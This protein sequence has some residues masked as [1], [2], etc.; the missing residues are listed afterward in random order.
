MLKTIIIIIII[1]LVFDIFVNCNWFD[2]RWQKYSTHL[3]K[4]NT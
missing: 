1:I 3:H 4:N 2:T